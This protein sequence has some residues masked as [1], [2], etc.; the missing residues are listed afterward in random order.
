MGSVTEGPPTINRPLRMLRSDLSCFN[1]WTKVAL[2]ATETVGRNLKKTKL[3]VN[4][5][6]LRETENSGRTNMYYCHCDFV[7]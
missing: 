1:S 5:E 7:K 2:W 4:R 6:K 3:R